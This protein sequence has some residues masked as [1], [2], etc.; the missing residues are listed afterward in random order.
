MA[1]RGKSGLVLMSLQRVFNYKNLPSRGNPAPVTCVLAQLYVCHTYVS[2]NTCRTR[3]YVNAH[4]D[5]L[6]LC[7]H[8]HMYGCNTYVDA[9]I[10]VCHIHVHAHVYGCNTFV[11]AK[12]CRTC[13]MCKC[14][15]RCMQ[16]TCKCKH[17]LSH[18][19]HSS[20]M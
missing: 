18:E 19:I 15:Y 16:Y 4:I 1:L 20:Y 9:H 2:T 3:S 17:L 5:V 13:Y 6:N 11:N 7:V 12:T 10:D 14:T 8:A